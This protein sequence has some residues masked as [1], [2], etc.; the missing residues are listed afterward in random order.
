MA[1]SMALAVLMLPTVIKTTDE[2]LKLV[3]DDLGV[4]PSA[5]GH[6]GSSP[7]FASPCLPH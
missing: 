5:W 2:G 6:P 1:G 7:L 4:A 3:P